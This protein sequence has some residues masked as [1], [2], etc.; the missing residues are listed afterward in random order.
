MTCS[1]RASAGM[2]I[3][4]YVLNA[5]HEAVALARARAVTA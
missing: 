5:F 3:P 1:G 4:D 2:R